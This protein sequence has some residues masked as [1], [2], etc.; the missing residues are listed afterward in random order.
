M[1]ELMI[2]NEDNQEVKSYAIYYTLNDRF[3]TIYTTKEKDENGYVILHIAKV[4][5]EV[6]NT[7]EGIVPTGKYIGLEISDQSEWDNAKVNIGEIVS[8][9]QNNTPTSVSY[10]PV[11][12]IN[13]ISIKSS[14]TFKLR[15][16]VV[17][18]IIVE[19]QTND[20]DTGV[21]VEIPVADI[22]TVTEEPAVDTVSVEEPMSL[23]AVAPVEVAPVDVNDFPAEIP[24]IA[25]VEIP[26]A[27]ESASVEPVAPEVP[28]VFNSEPT[29]DAS[30]PAI[31]PNPFEMQ[32]DIEI[33]E[34]V[35]EE[36]VKVN[37]YEVMQQQRAEEMINALATDDMQ[38]IVAAP[39]I[40]VTELES[41][42]EETPAETEKPAAPATV[43]ETAV[44]EET[45]EEE[46]PAEEPKVDVV[47]SESFVDS[48]VAD[49]SDILD[50]KEEPTPEEKEDYERLYNDALEKTVE[51]EKELAELHKK[52]DNIKNI[53]E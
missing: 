52:I 11:S 13:G 15:E 12:E 53:V 35:V 19:S 51:L 48:I 32:P 4:L 14:K 16:D 39:V 2:F 17:D 44:E 42:V 20:A 24:A 27:E 10:L 33:P 36:E 1:N 25:P 9:K 38:D 47:S 22:P 41:K 37:P 7:P 34:P 21:Q 8:N 45:V 43:E 28:N 3:Y 30:A 23:D 18:S 49:V 5:K 50:K 6:N 26:V 46:T 29:V 31:A 40:P